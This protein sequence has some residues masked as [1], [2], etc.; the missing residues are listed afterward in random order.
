MGAADPASFRNRTLKTSSPSCPGHGPA[1]FLTCQALV[2][3]QCGV[4]GSKGPLRVSLV[5]TALPFLCRSAG[6]QRLVRLPHISPQGQW[7][8]IG[9]RSGPAPRGRGAWAGP[10]RARQGTEGLSVCPGSDDGSVRLWEVATARCMRTV[11][12][13]G[14]GE[15]CRLEPPHP[16]ICLVAAAVWREAQGTLRVGWGD[17]PMPED[18]HLTLTVGGHGAAEPSPGGPAGGG[19]STDQLLSA[20]TPPVEPT[21]QPA[22]WLEASR[23]SARGGRALTCLWK[24]G[25]GAEGRAPGGGRD[26]TQPHLLQPVA[27]VAW[28]GGTTRPRVLAT[29]G[30]PRC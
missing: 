13:D 24:A 6:P 20:F 8:G 16:T 27:Q 10:W 12:M 1:A 29:P 14:C 30:T 17:R 2:S 28:H 26:L 9:G 18:L 15:E 4:V 5:F 11:P 25:C 7:L 22:H 19:G 21:S 3:R 23:G